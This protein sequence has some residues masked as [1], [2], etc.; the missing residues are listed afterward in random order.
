MDHREVNLIQ[1]AAAAD[2]PVTAVGSVGAPGAAGVAP[3]PARVKRAPGPGKS[4]P[5]PVCAIPVVVRPLSLGARLGAALYRGFEIL[6]ALVALLLTLP[7]LLLIAVRVRLDSP[8]PVLFSHRRAGRSVPRPGRALIG[9]TD[10]QAPEGGFQPDQLYWVPSTFR[11]VKFR[12][13]HRDAVE[14]FPELYWWHYDIDPKEFPNLYYQRENDPRLTPFGKWLRKTSLDELPNFWNVLVGDIR[15]VGPRPEH[16]E[17]LAYYTAEQ[18]LKFTVKPGLTCLSMVHGRGE[19][20]VGEKIQ[21]DLE[22]VRNRSLWLDLKILAR[23][24]W[25]VVTGRGAF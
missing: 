10:L 21:L 14:R 5:R 15:L 1:A 7:V 2:C 8:G 19:L 4:T 16:P 23:T 9:R 13:M 17:L 22:Y 18:L 25:V 3:R 12:T 20:S 24:A 11:F 6:V